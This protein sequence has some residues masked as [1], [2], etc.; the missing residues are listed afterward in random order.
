MQKSMPWLGRN[1]PTRSVLVASRSSTAAQTLNRRSCATMSSRTHERSPTR[2]SAQTTSSRTNSQMSQSVH[3]SP[4]PPIGTAPRKRSAHRL[5]QTV[6]ESETVRQASGWTPPFRNHSCNG[7]SD[8]RQADLETMD[9]D[10][11][12]PIDMD[13]SHATGDLEYTV[14]HVVVDKQIQ[15]SD[16][17]AA[18]DVSFPP[19]SVPTIGLE[20]P[21]APPSPEQPRYYRLIEQCVD[22]LVIAPLD[23]QHIENACRLVP[24]VYRRRYRSVV[25]DLSEVWGLLY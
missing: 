10:H 17:L 1:S 9:D 3:L 15:D 19:A 12:S 13:S 25:E 7:S 6:R 16:T 8:V 2:A 14:S 21:A 11:D 20:R 24:A 22:P 5:K 4:S 23:P 18:L